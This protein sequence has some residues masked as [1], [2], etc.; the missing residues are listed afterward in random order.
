MGYRYYRR[1]WNEP[2]GDQFAHW[3]ASLW[4]FEIDEDGFPHRQ[5]E[6]YENGPVL[7]YSRDHPDDEFGMLGD[8]AVD[9]AEFAPFEISEQE[10]ERAWSA[11][12]RVSTIK[13][14]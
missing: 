13:A 11:P 8:Q 1:G 12:G 5:I 7:K 2:R 14:G 6:G 3:G 4:Y 10:F 9:A